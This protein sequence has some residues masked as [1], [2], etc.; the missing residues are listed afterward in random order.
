MVTFCFSMEH[1]GFEPLTSTLPVWR[2]PNCANAPGCELFFSRLHSI[3]VLFGT[4]KKNFQ[5]YRK[6]KTPYN[7]TCKKNCTEKLER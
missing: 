5:I 3:A 2:A 4:I 7:D 1:R 6:K